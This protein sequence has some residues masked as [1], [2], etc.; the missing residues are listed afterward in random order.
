MSDLVF[1][2]DRLRSTR[3]R[4]GFTQA[5]LA[6]RLGLTRAAISQ[7]ESTDTKSVRGDNLFPLAD[8]LGVNARWLM[9]GKG[10]PGD[11]ADTVVPPLSKEER[12]ARHLAALPDDKLDALITLLGIK[13]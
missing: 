13:L 10:D 4:R 3:E 8:A 5:D 9:T 11:R 7:L 2:A 1:F 12:I 6:R